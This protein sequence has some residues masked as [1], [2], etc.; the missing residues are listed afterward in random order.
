LTRECR[1]RGAFR[2][3]SDGPESG[4]DDYNKQPSSTTSPSSSPTSATL[5]QEVA[6][7]SEVHHYPA[8]QMA[9]KITA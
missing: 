5:T 7:T 4:G 6:V 9:I 2:G 1:I 8:L 3:P